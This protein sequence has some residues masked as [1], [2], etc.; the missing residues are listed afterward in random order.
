[1]K[2]K[3]FYLIS[4]LVRNNAIQAINA[5]ELD[6]KTKVSVGSAGTKSQRQRGLQHIWYDDVVKSGI[7]GAM[8]ETHNGVDSFA[9]RN[10]AMPIM[11]QNPEK[12]ENF[13]YMVD[14]LNSENIE[15]PF[16]AYFFHEHCHTEWFDTQE[17]AEFLTSFQIYYTNQGV[18][19]SD[20]ID[21]KLLKE[22]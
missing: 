12:Y 4:D 9:K 17:M 15:F 18:N 2:A 11:L 1:M 20:P 22:A 3:N 10:F 13:L 16:A 7:G 19:L 5:A 6:G 21:Y 8:E 14:V